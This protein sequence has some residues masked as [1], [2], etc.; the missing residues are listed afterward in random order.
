[1]VNLTRDENSSKSS[2]LS[3]TSG[4]GTARHRGSEGAHNDG[5]VR[6]EWARSVENAAQVEAAVDLLSNQVVS[7][8]AVD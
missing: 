7:P 8:T 6:R 3:S 2:A 5:E 1:M 4:D